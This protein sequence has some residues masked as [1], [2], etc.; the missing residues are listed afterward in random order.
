[1]KYSLTSDL[2]SCIHVQSILRPDSYGIWVGF[3]FYCVSNPNSGGAGGGGGGGIGG[4][5]VIV[6]GIGGCGGGGG[7][8]DIDDIFEENSNMLLKFRFSLH[9]T[10]P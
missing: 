9:W 10:F 3:L 6:G 4:G 1:M 2:Q 8:D 5:G 7:D